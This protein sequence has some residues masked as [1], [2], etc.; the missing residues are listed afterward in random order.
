MGFIDIISCARIISSVRSC[1]S[2]LGNSCV[3][4]F[5]SSWVVCFVNPRDWV[6]LF[7][8]TENI[9]HGL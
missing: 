6:V 9:E 4:L 3:S 5:G 1:D 2:L 8:N 7:V